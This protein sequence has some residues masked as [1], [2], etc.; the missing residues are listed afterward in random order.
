MLPCPALAQVVTDVSTRSV[1]IALLQTQSLESLLCMK[2]MPPPTSSPLRPLTSRFLRWQADFG[3]GS[4]AT[5]A[6]DTDARAPRGRRRE[7]HA[8]LQCH[9]GESGQRASDADGCLPAPCRR[10]PDPA[11]SPALQVNPSAPVSSCH[12]A[13]ETASAPLSPL[14]F[15]PTMAPLFASPSQSFSQWPQ[16]GTAR[17]PGFCR[18]QSA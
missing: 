7:H 2:D 1:A 16:A 3:E 11:Q 14:R 10:R 17:D 9:D 12:H 15:R 5:R 13:A 4:R 6:V 18:R 8:P